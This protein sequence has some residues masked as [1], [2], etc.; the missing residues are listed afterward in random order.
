MLRIAPTAHAARTAPS[1]SFIARSLPRPRLAALALSFAIGLPGAA[2]SAE[3]DSVT[4]NLMPL[5]GS[6]QQLDLKTDMRMAMAMELG[7]GAPES[8]RANAAKLAEAG[9]FTMQSEMRQTVVTTP[10][11]KDG[12]YTMQAD[13]VTLKSE[14]RDAQGNV[15]P[16]PSM[17]KVV[18]KAGLKDDQI[19]SVHVEMDPN[20]PMAQA[21]TQE[22]SQQIFDKSFDWMRKFNG[23]TLK[24]GESIELPMDVALPP[25]VAAGMGKVVGRYTLTDLTK[26]IASFDVGV[27]MDMSMTLPT[28]GASAA[29]GAAPAPAESASAADG[30]GQATMTGAGGGKMVIRMADRLILR[31]DM[32]LTLDMDIGVQPGVR[33]KMKMEMDM[34][35]VGKTLAA[36]KGAAPAKKTKG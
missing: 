36:A 22:M 18:F 33:M 29:S 9:R 34:Q 12:S 1:A 27:K 28:P 10:K 6:R 2:M 14:M 35:G 16:M 19:Q 11:A 17:G 21:W 31:N 30:V 15:K 23:T 8:A 25:Q 3:P 13:M 24:V 7:P 20:S 5:P 26:G 4:M 32:A